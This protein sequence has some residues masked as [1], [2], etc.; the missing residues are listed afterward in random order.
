VRL[1]SACQGAEGTAHWPDAGGIND[2]AAW[3]VD[4]FRALANADHRMREQRSKRG[5]E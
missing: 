1:W 3:V 4:A 5:G 2:Q